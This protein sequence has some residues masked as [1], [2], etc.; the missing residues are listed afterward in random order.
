MSYHITGL[1]SA[2]LYGLSVVG[3]WIQLQK[4]LERK[5]SNLFE[6]PTAIISLNFMAMAFYAFFF[7]FVYGFALERFNH[8]L[9]W[10]RLSAMAVS[11]MILYHIMQDRED[12][13]ST[14]VFYICAT[15]TLG[16]LLALIFFREAAHLLIPFSQIGIV[17]ITITLTQAN[18]HQISLIAR[19][20][21]T[22][23]IALRSHQLTL[24]KDLGTVA[25]GLV[26]GTAVGW[27]LLLL[28][29]SNALLKLAI[30]Y[31]F[32]WVKVSPKAQQRRQVATAL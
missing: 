8:Y 13:R 15:S 3:L 28:C 7:L 20:G 26:L 4:I 22:G 32:R 27:P 1:I 18:I 23:G 14:I 21:S 11:L 12:L 16:G 17:A 19:S 10:P 6:R 9:V 25:F 24:I 5:R 30:M 29:G 2:F 31:L